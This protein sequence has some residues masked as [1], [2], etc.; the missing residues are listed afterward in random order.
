MGQRV[1]MDRERNSQSGDKANYQE[2]EDPDKT[3]EIEQEKE[4]Q[5]PREQPV[6]K[7]RPKQR[8]SY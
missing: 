8:S 4:E 6:E 3:I 7:E 1:N 2:Y 5:R